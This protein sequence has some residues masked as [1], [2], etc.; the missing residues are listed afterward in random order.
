MHG[1]PL[2][3]YLYPNSLGM[4]DSWNPLK[5]LAVASFANL[6]GDIVLCS[7][8]GYGIAGAAWATMAS[9]VSVKILIPP[10]YVTSIYITSMSL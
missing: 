10:L 6:F 8:C 4:Q 3:V 2:H 9:Q 7:I 5:V 1:R